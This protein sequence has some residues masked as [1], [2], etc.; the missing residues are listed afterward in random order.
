LAIAA[1]H[2]RDDTCEDDPVSR[3]I[4]LVVLAVVIAATTLVVIEGQPKI[5][6][7]TTQL[8]T[9]P[10]L[11]EGFTLLACTHRTTIGLKGCAEHRLL[12]Q[13]HLINQLRDRVVRL[14]IGDGA[15]RQFFLAER[16]W[17][18]YRQAACLSESDSNEGGSLAPLDFALC[19]LRLD[20]QHVTDLRVQQASYAVH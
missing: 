12:V 4:A 1:H 9:P 15:R 13:D 2:S 20:R 5:V 11:H 14:L 3:M 19:A 8:S 10:Q 6:A 7:T 17:F 18:R 16:A